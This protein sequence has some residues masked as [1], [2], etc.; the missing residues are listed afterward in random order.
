MIFALLGYI[1][2]AFSLSYCFNFSEMAIVNGIW[3][4]ISILTIA[5]MG[6]ILF[7]EK[8]TTRKILALVLISIAIV[9]AIK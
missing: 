9:L 8:L 6:W 1:I 5:I 7:G 4:G 3:N 2:L